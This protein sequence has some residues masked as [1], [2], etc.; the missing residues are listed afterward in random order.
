MET[1]SCS[2]YNFSLSHYFTYHILQA[3]PAPGVKNSLARVAAMV[4]APW[5]AAMDT[6]GNL[7]VDLLHCTFDL[8]QKREFV[9]LEESV[10]ISGVKHFVCAHFVFSGRCALAVYGGLRFEALRHPQQY[11]FSLPK[12]IL[13][14]I[15]TLIGSSLPPV[16]SLALLLPAEVPAEPEKKEET[17]G[18]VF[19]RFE[20]W[21][22]E[23][24]IDPEAAKVSIAKFARDSVAEPREAMAVV[25][26]LSELRKTGAIQL[27]IRLF[28][29]V[30][31]AH[32]ESFPKGSSG[33]AE[34]LKAVLDGVGTLFIKIFQCF[35]ARLYS[36]NEEHARRFLSAFGDEASACEYIIRDMPANLLE[37]RMIKMLPRFL[38]REPVK[39]WLHH[40]LAENIDVISEAIPTIC[41]NLFFKRIGHMFPTF[42]DSK[43][44]LIEALKSALTG[45]PRYG[46]LPFAVTFPRLCCSENGR[47]VSAQAVEFAGDVCK[48][49]IPCMSPGQIRKLFTCCNEWADGS[50]HNYYIPEIVPLLNE[51]QLDALVE[52]SFWKPKTNMLEAVLVGMGSKAP[53]EVQV[54]IARL[55]KQAPKRNFLVGAGI[56]SSLILAGVSEESKEKARYM[57]SCMAAEIEEVDLTPFLVTKKE[58]PRLHTWLLFAVSDKISEAVVIELFKDETLYQYQIDIG[59]PLLPLFATWWR[60]G[61]ISETAVIEMIRGDKTS[62]MIPFLV[63]VS[64]ELINLEEHLVGPSG[65]ALLWVIWRQLFPEELILYFWRYASIEQ[66]ELVFTREGGAALDRAIV[67]A[68]QHYKRPIEGVQPD[69]MRVL[70]AAVKT[71]GH[72]LQSKP[73]E[74]L[75][76]MLLEEGNVVWVNL[77]VKI[78]YLLIKADPRAGSAF[79]KRLVELDMPAQHLMKSVILYDPHFKTILMHIDRSQYALVHRALDPIFDTLKVALERDSLDTHGESSESFVDVLVGMPTEMFQYFLLQY[80]WT[81]EQFTWIRDLIADRIDIS[82]ADVYDKMLCLWKTDPALSDQGSES[83]YNFLCCVAENTPQI[84][85]NAA[86]RYLSKKVVPGTHSAETLQQLDSHLFA[87]VV[88][89]DILV[90]KLVLADLRRFAPQ[91]VHVWPLWNTQLTA[92]EIH[93]ILEQGFAKGLLEAATLISKEQIAPC[94]VHVAKYYEVL[95]AA[96][97]QLEKDILEPGASGRVLEMQGQVSELIKWMVKIN[98]V[99]GEALPTKAAV[100]ML[101]SLTNDATGLLG[102]LPKV[103]PVEL[104]EEE[105]PIFGHLPKRVRRKALASITN[106]PSERWRI[107][108]AVV[109]KIRERFRVPSET[110]DM[111][112]YIAL[113]CD[114]KEDYAALLTKDKE[115]AYRAEL[116]RYVNGILLADAV[117]DSASF[118]SYLATFQDPS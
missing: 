16:A 109:A 100:E 108:S 69:I 113:F 57:W 26:A 62:L 95:T 72:F 80:T 9:V 88:V 58:L 99:V 19:R 92:E 71:P 66:L 59:Y 46:V 60:F 13:P 64:A 34:H 110:C 21:L 20:G 31:S 67:C 61:K 115:M 82:F 114:Y 87:L 112:L 33:K 104:P 96:F 90:G 73:I 56:G 35:S 48:G 39:R 32:R 77:L 22:S 117:T 52:V 44:M 40:T 55:F 49:V 14:K 8:L 86:Q 118:L 75:C 83:A 65:E 79:L 24:T 28:G 1:L 27:P 30:M 29:A 89:G 116:L 45:N 51:S 107:Q 74:A 38:H 15:A 102:K 81:Q 36:I 4:A 11:S 17:W 70:N 50:K 93:F 97:V 94:I 103:Q 3:A 85:V 7:V 53:E 10:P 23:S 68:T 47:R 41:R 98:G 5:L 101:T 106:M 43:E 2:G 76:A 37:V 25:G 105:H 91:L 18:D 111:E 63:S 6:S 42:F 78:T 84:L 54:F 12:K